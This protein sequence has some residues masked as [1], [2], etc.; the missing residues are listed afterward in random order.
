V[1]VGRRTTYGA[2]FKRLD[3]LRQGDEIFVTTPYGRFPFR[4][5]KTATL[6]P[7]KAD[8]LAT[9]KNGLLTLVTSDPPYAPDS[10][11]VVEA[12][13]TSDPSSFPNPPLAKGRAGAVYLTGNIGALP[14]VALSGMLLVA[15]IA[16]AQVLYQR[17]RAWPTY[18]L[19][20]PVVLALLFMWM[21]GLVSIMPATL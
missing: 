1:I 10:A 2:P 20:T 3:V 14:G 13:L 19:T 7:G 4:V 15:A 5:Q 6:E 17:W 18:L 8:N 11:L 12:E 16:I 21:E 9:S